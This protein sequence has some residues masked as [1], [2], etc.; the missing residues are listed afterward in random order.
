MDTYLSY[1]KSKELETFFSEDIQFE[2]AFDEGKYSYFRADSVNQKIP[3]EKILV[4]FYSDYD[5]SERQKD[6]ELVGSLCI[7]VGSDVHLASKTLDLDAQTMYDLYTGQRRCS[8]EQWIA[9]AISEVCPNISRHEP[10]KIAEVTKDILGIGTGRS[11]PTKG[12]A[13]KAAKDFF[14]FRHERQFLDRFLSGVSSRVPGLNLPS[15]AKDALEERSAKAAFDETIAMVFRPYGLATF[16]PEFQKGTLVEATFD[17]AVL[18]GVRFY[19]LYFRSA[20]QSEA[21]DQEPDILFYRGLHVTDRG[22][23]LFT[24][25]GRQVPLE[26]VSPSL[27]QERDLSFHTKAAADFKLLQSAGKGSLSR[28]RSLDDTIRAFEN[29]RKANAKTSEVHDKDRSVPQ[30]R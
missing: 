27:S 13:R 23:L 11:F 2:Y 1:L 9:S 18:D 29:L 16:M 14:T 4:G 19:S 26:A 21:P 5:P 7:R 6:H 20:A 24:D 8:L 30:A 12:Y 17:D 15:V 28:A 3:G 10:R 25:N 22:I